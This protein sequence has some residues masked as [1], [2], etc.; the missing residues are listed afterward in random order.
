M[1]YGCSTGFRMTIWCSIA[2]SPMMALTRSPSNSTAKARCC[3]KQKRYGFN[4]E[5]IEVYRFRSMYID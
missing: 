3:S 1:K 5:L 4:N 2:T